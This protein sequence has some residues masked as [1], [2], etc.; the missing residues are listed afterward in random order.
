MFTETKTW[1]EL[2]EVKAKIYGDGTAITRDGR[3]WYWD[4][5]LGFGV[6]LRV[7]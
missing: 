2:V 6:F 5:S 1:A 3:H 4:G 7:Q